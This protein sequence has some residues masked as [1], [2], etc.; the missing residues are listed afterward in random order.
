MSSGHKDGSVMTR[1]TDGII[2]HSKLG[3]T[4]TDTELFVL[5]AN[6]RIAFDNVGVSTTAK[7]RTSDT[8]CRADTKI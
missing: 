8:V 4:A 6:T 1:L 5:S 2:I 3:V 7:C